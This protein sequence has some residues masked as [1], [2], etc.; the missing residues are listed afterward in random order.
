MSD[1]W[2]ESCGLKKKQRVEAIAGSSQDRMDLLDDLLEEDTSVFPLLDVPPEV[3]TAVGIFLDARHLT[4]L[5]QLNAQAQSWLDDALSDAW[6]EL[7]L[8]D[9]AFKSRAKRYKAFS[10]GDGDSTRAFNGSAGLVL[11]AAD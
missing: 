4:F 7:L 11:T 1:A 2:L 5:S 8:R 3:L 9:Y 6:N 10:T